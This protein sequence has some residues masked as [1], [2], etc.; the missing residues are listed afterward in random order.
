M[1]VGVVFKISSQLFNGVGVGVV[2]IAQNFFVREKI[3]FSGIFIQCTL[4]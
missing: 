4:N 3:S 1:R 2:V